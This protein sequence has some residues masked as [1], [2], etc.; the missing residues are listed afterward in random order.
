MC[1]C[2]R[3]TGAMLL[4]LRNCGVAERRKAVLRISG[5]SV[6]RRSVVWRLAG[7]RSTSRADSV[8]AVIS[9]RSCDLRTSKQTVATAEA[10]S[11]RKLWSG[12]CFRAFAARTWRDVAHGEKLCRPFLRAPKLDLGGAAGRRP[13][14][15]GAERRTGESCKRGAGGGGFTELAGWAA[16]YRSGMSG[17][18]FRGKLVGGAF[19]KKQ[20]RWGLVWGFVRCYVVL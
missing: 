9:A 11:E 3:A 15:E 16:G 8:L 6:L 19:K 17:A 1:G 2:Q 4:V 13:E 14:L 7:I 5:A 10:F 18:R 20:L 12:Q